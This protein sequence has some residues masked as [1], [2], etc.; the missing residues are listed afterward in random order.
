M[1]PKLTLSES[2]GDGEQPIQPPARQPGCCYLQPL[3]NGRI[4]R[5]FIL[6]ATNGCLSR[7]V[8]NWKLGGKD[9]C[10]ISWNILLGLV[11]QRLLSD[12]SH[13]AEKY[14][15]CLAMEIGILWKCNHEVIRRM[16][17]EVDVLLLNLDRGRLFFVHTICQPRNPRNKGTSCRWLL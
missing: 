5:C 15:S 10:V 14:L 17:L 4:C 16:W 8:A 6:A 2:T 3:S 12:T 9:R 13:K 1:I 7:A 11:A